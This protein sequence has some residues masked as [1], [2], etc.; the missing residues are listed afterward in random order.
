M[1]LHMHKP[2]QAIVETRAQHSSVESGPN[3]DAVAE[4]AHLSEHK[5]EH[6]IQTDRQ[7]QGQQEID[8]SIQIPGTTGA[9]DKNK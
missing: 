7:R 5:Y 6:D 8:W 9:W 2:I 1:Y 3:E 4:Y